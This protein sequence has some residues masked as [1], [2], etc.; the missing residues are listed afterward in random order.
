M[1]GAGDNGVECVVKHKRFSLPTGL[2]ATR[3]NRAPTAHSSSRNGPTNHSFAF[4]SELMR[5]AWFV[6]PR[7][8]SKKLTT[9]VVPDVP[10]PWVDIQGDEGRLEPPRNSIEG[11]PPPTSKNGPFMMD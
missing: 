1:E 7:A 3:R 5:N 9:S 6:A 10:P 4:E 2:N 11:A 8:W